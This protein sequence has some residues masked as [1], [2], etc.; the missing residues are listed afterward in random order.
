[1]VALI[2][3]LSTTVFFPITILVLLLPIVFFRETILHRNNIFFQKKEIYAYIL[4][5][6]VAVIVNYLNI[7]YG[8]VIPNV[9]EGSILGNV[10]YV[11]LLPFAFLIGKFINLKDLKWLQYFIVLEIIVGCLEYYYG[12][13]TFFV[14][15][16]PVTELAD[17]DILY[18][19]RVFG[20]S[21]NSS[22]LAAKVVYLTVLTMMQIKLD[23]KINR[24]LIFFIFFIF[25]GLI[26]TFNRTAIISVILSAFILFG[27]S[28][29]G[30]VLIS[31][32]VVGGLFYN[33][34]AIYE[35]LTRGRGT[36]DLSGRDQI[37]SYFYHFWNENVLLGNMGTKL[38][39]NNMGSIWHAHNSYLEFLASNG[40]LPTLLFLVSFLMLFSRGL[41][42]VLPILVFSLS[43]YGFLWGL[44]FYDIVFSAIVYNYIKLNFKEAK[45]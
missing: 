34:E 1:M 19:K 18:Q 11:L 41:S 27:M 25:L 43:Q 20:F 21:A 33:R 29:R 37:F 5:F 42:I 45:P 26:V 30:F 32:P 28:L 17:T 35:Q 15:N 24:E 14:N 4:M 31:I 40:L 16:T 12:V 13:P 9:Q 22:N 7:F 36:V 3:F 39:W 23:K 44:S 8:A 6:L 38:W 2:L 10:P